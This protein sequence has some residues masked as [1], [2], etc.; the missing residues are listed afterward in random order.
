MPIRN[1]IERSYLLSYVVG[2]PSIEILA[3][4]DLP[5]QYVCASER[6][7]HYIVAEIGV[8]FRSVADGYGWGAF[9]DE[10]VVLV[11]V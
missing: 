9:E 7:L 10:I 4:I 3:N 2:L 11:D 6:P 1:T 5:V 8:L